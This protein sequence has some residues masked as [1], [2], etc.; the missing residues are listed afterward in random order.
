MR[1]RNKNRKRENKANLM[2][3]FINDTCNRRIKNVMKKYNISGNLISKPNV[4]LEKFLRKRPK[5]T[6]DCGCEICKD[7]GPKYSCADRY[8]VYQY[9]CKTCN[10]NYIGKTSRPF[11][12]RHQ[13][14]KSSIKNNTYNSALSQHRS[15]H[16][17][18]G[19]QDFIIQFLSK[20]S[21]TRDVTI[22]ESK[23]IRVNKPEINR[24][25][26]INCYPLIASTT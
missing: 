22:E 3:P 2:I 17:I 26:E 16:P 18:K 6:K 23:C 7:I 24:K 9:T 25:N 12:I 13:E 21:N 19:I 4:S 15:K 10:E 11:K 5:M 20:K 8:V 1:R 14:H